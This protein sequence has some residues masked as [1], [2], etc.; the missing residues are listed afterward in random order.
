[1]PLAAVLILLLPAISA[2]QPV[3]SFDQLST[4]LKPGD[5]VYVTDAQG[6]EIEGKITE[7]HDASITLNSEGPTT[8]QANN[9]RAVQRRTKSLGK[10]A[11]WGAL[12]GGVLGAVTGAGPDDRLALGA[13][14]AAVGAGV[15]A[16]VRA[17]LPPGRKEVYRAPGASGSAHLS[18][19]PVITPRTKG[20]AV[21]FSF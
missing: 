8:L 17:A 2:A 4:R 3:K 7:L 20:V 12:V 11:L 15:G 14:G 21:A 9:V 6:R 18:V 13:I 10:A 1:M 5:T 19:A 16:A